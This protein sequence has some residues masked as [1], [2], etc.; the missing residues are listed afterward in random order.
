MRP[1]L[2]ISSIL[3]ALVAAPI[4]PLQAQDKD[5]ICRDVRNRPM[6][7]GQWAGYRWTGGRTDA[8]TIRFA[9][10]GTEAYQGS[11]HY[12]YEMQLTDPSKGDKG[13]T[14]IQ[15]LVPN[16]GFQ[17]GVVRGI[18]MKSGTEPAMRMPE[19]MVAMMGSRMASSVAAEMTRGCQ[20]M[21]VVGWEEV[22]VP[23]GTFR[24]L[25]VRHAH[26]KTEAWIRPELYFGLVRATTKDG[27]MVLT[28]HGTDAR[29]AIT[30]TPQDPMGR[31]N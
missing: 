14:I 13:R 24:A 5:Q 18:V 26:E 1:T 15:M 22:T 12:W 17:Q 23:A 2:A 29:S 28:G 27:T 8:T 30:E 3:A 31:R 7:V 10:V 6:R 19:Q 16:L 25:H 9:V 4:A 20:E 21:D 11:P